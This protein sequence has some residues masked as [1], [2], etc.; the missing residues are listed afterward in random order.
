MLAAWSFW[1]SIAL[2]AYVYAGYPLLLIVLA[3]IMGRP[4]HKGAIEPT[5]SLVVPAYNEQA[6][7]AEKI[8]VA[9]K[10]DYPA[11]RYEIVVVS[12]GSS[13]RTVEIAQ[14]LEDGEQVRVLAFAQNRG[15][16]AALNEA[17]EGLRNEIVVFSDAS[18]MPARESLRELVSNFADPS[19]GAV[20]GVYQVLK[21]DQA[22]LGRQESLYWR[23]ETFL[24]LKEAEID[25]IL[26]CHGSLYGIRRE[27]YP[28]PATTTIND[29]YVI[30]LRILHGGWR[31][32]YEPKA[33]A[34]EEAE[35]M[36]GFSRRV[37]IM[38]GNFEQLKEIGGLLSPLRAKPLF[39]FLSHKVGRL[40]A[41]LAM[42]VALASNIALL[43]SPFYTAVLATQA[44]FYALAAA[45]ISAALRPKVLRLPY[46]FTMINVATLFGLYYAYVARRRLRWKAKP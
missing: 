29:D 32:A 26:G 12:D 42:I 41:P 38:A 23:Y 17:L 15:K 8:A 16:I 25:S 36:G 35:E 5:V 11:E 24:K 28:F 3:R 39:F 2:V 19:V 14:S 45:G 9:R 30:P 44:A 40:L 4:V 31:V 46:Y 1:S 21:S 10:L 13:D 7:I 37:R 33:V 34:Y 43:P 22:Q 20:S 6:C 18:S 27:L